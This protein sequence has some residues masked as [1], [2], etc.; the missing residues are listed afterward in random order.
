M[1]EKY[2]LS[3]TGS[4]FALSP[5]AR[6]AFASAL[7]IAD[8]HCTSEDVGIVI[9]LPTAPACCTSFLAAAMSC[10]GSG[11]ELYACCHWAFVAVGKNPGVTR[12][13][14][15]WPSPLNAV[16]MTPL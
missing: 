1:P 6:A 16:W 14:A 12:E 7:P 13:R 15:G 11:S 5:A 4:T 3:G 10:L 9:V 8:S 2:W